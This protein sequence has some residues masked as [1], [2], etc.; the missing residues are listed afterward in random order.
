[1]FPVLFLVKF[2]LA[3]QADDGVGNIA[4]LNIKRL[5]LSF[6]E[7]RRIYNLFICFYFYFCFVLNFLIIG[8][9][10]LVYL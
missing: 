8:T 10:S 2:F 9:L 7:T 3:R 1:M 4:V 6:G 5:F